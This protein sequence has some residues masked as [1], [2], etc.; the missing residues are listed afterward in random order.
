QVLD[1]PDDFDGGQS[2]VALV[3]RHP[4]VQPELFDHH[5]VIDAGAFQLPIEG[6]GVYG[7]DEDRDDPL[8]N[9]SQP[10]QVGDIEPDHS[11]S[12]AGIDGQYL[13][14]NLFTSASKGKRTVSPFR[15]VF[16]MA[17]SNSSTM[18]WAHHSASP[19]ADHLGNSRRRE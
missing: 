16:V 5:G 13:H 3:R 11:R 17:S 10:N 4:R 1:N 14:P 6:G 12:L 8:P 15:H 2:R 9:L 19:W 18:I 7:S